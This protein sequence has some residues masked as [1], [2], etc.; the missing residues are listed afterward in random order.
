MAIFKRQLQ[1]KPNTI[2][3][4]YRDNNFEQTLNSGYHEFWDFKNR[5]ELFSLPTTSKL[6]CVTNQEVL[7]KDNVALRFSFNILYKITDGDRKS[8]V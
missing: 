4:L 5:I 3:Y 8:V 1:V 6:I 7:T 2:G